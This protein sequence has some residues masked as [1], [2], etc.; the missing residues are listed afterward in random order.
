M[1]TVCASAGASEA[2]A[3]ITSSSGADGFSEGTSAA[4]TSLPESAA[5]PAA[6]MPTAPFASSSEALPAAVVSVEGPTASTAVCGAEAKLADVASAA[7]S[8]AGAPMPASGFAAAELSPAAWA[9]VAAA[10]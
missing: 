6:C 10:A 2:I 3:A 7:F 9:T 4:C 5:M 8:S 1:D